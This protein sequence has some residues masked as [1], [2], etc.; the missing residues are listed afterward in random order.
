[1]HWAITAT[2]DR[3]QY[4]PAEPVQLQVLVTGPAGGQSVLRVQVS[5]R[6]QGVDA[7]ERPISLGDSGLW[8]GVVTVPLPTGG[9]VWRAFGLDLTLWPPGEAHP[10]EDAG[11][12]SRPMAEHS[13]SC[14]VAPHWQ[15]APRYGVLTDFAPQGEEDDRRRLDALLALHVNCVQ[16]Y[17][18]MYTHHTYLPPTEIFTDPLGRSLDFGRVRRRVQ[19]CRELGMAPI[20]YA[21]VY[22]AENPFATE[23]SDWLLYD[24]DGQPMSL[25]GIFFIQDPSPQSGWRRHLMSQ[26]QAALDLGFLGLHCDTYG[27][28]KAG[29]AWRGSGS[30]ER[31]DLREVFPGL[32]AE[33]DALTRA[34]HDE[35][36]AI[37]N[38]VGVWPLEVMAS[39]PAAALYVEVWP[40]MVTYRDLYEIVQRARRV[41]PEKQVVLAAYLS[42]FHRD[43]E[44]PAGAL[45]GLRLA[46]ATIFA[47]GGYHLLPAEGDGALAD[48]YYPLY[49]QL[50]A[51][52]WDVLRRYWDFQTRYG[53]LLADPLALDITTTHL[54]NFGREVHVSG[55]PCSALADGGRLWTLG[56]EGQDY[57]VLHFINLTSA[58][59]P[60]W[61]TAQSD[62]RPTEPLTVDL[63]VLDEPRAVWAASPDVSSPAA[64][65]LPYTLL[66]RSGVGLVLRVEVPP[67]RVWSML[68][69]ER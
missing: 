28:P 21:S 45:T 10:G 9:P 48:A 56:R 2:P 11:G 27:S 15:V 46:A 1:M 67:V 20:A 12:A 63:E 61:N 44:R 24:G 18:W 35:G 52:E 17:D 7:L 8:E 41:A 16:F 58:T 22:G 5:E 53:P 64:M 33:A 6:A 31:V 49:G 59:D 14:D 43:R 36:G 55:A 39:A 32:M 65:P 3:G 57:T 42:P 26:Y 19:A 54:G 25:G 68:V 4:R 40:P 66:H 50:D 51:A 69:V 13:T 38:C 23:H 47:S 62:P 60:T 29:L 37:F 34:H 30:K